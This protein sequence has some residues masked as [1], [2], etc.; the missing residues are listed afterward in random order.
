MGALQLLEVLHLLISSVTE[1]AVTLVLSLEEPTPESPPWRSSVLSPPSSLRSSVL[2]PPSSLHSPDSP[3][4]PCTQ[5][6]PAS[7]LFVDYR[8]TWAQVTGL[9]EGDSS[10][11]S[12]D[13]LPEGR[14]M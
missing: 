4:E 6:G 9:A 13:S 12:S 1:T 5:R 3:G 10:L 8:I 11:C 14:M 7:P 2:S